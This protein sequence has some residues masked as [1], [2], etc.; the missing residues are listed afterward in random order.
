MEKIKK[1]LD[2]SVDKIQLEVIHTGIKKQKRVNKKPEVIYNEAGER[3]TKSGKLYTEVKK[4]SIE[5]LKK[6]REEKARRRAEPLP[7]EEEKED[8]SDEEANEYVIEEIAITKPEPKVIEK[9]VVKEVVK[10]EPD[11]K[12]VEENNQLKEKN[13]KLEETFF[14]NQHLSRIS[15]ISR[16][17]SMRF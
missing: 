10:I 7:K 6:Y 8:E 1:T 16:A 2:K 13:K 12:V 4:N 15:N 5:A 17:V 11:I 3:I 9:E 14:F